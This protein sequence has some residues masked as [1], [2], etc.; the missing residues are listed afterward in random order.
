MDKS[1]I[2]QLS[3]YDKIFNQILNGGI[4]TD[5]GVISNIYLSIK[6]LGMAV[7]FVLA[8]KAAIEVVSSGGGKAID[9]FKDIVTP[10]FY[11]FVLYFWLDILMMFD[12]VAGFISAAINKSVTIG[13]QSGKDKFQEIINALMAQSD[14][15]TL[16]EKIAT[17]DI[18]SIIPI[19]IY[20]L[21]TL[22]WISVSIDELVMTLFYGYSQ[23]I[24]T[25][26][27]MTGIIALILSF[28]GQFDSFKTWLKNFISVKLW[29]V[30]AFMV[31]YMVD[32]LYI[33]YIQISNIVFSA[34]PDASLFGMMV[35]QIAIFTAFGI[36]KL[37]LMFK[38]PQIVSMFIGSSSGSGGVF[39]VM[40]APVKIGMEA[41]KAAATGG[42][43]MVS[44]FKK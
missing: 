22:Q 31:F 8:I 32:Q 6:W 44:K 30:I 39:G 12:T 36:L 19:H 7:L 37:V 14:A 33:Y 21:K 34:I 41:G 18:S 11:M 2:T 25:L 5:G 24:L 42:K 43:S 4:D 10:M 20:F 1:Y 26:L 15:K 35:Q 23:I 38:V 9:P 27:K 40:F 16:F 13:N 3:E 29:L 28:T 17:M